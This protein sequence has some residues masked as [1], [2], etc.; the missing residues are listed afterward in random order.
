M[1]NGQ[2]MITD[3]VRCAI[4]RSTITMRVVLCCP[5][6]GI[7]SGFS[8]LWLNYT[9]EPLIS[10]KSIIIFLLDILCREEGLYKRL[11]RKKQTS[12]LYFM[13]QLLLLIS[14]L[15]YIMFRDN[16]K[17]YAFP[18]YCEPGDVISIN[19]SLHPS[20]HYTYRL[21]VRVGESQS[22]LAS[23]LRRIPLWGGH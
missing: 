12:G 11:K 7:E 2:A 19:P 22:Q 13:N 16:E 14:I 18:M 3:R 21:S 10:L 20:I 9:T 1:E 17:V 6:C 5:A 4:K 8:E 15:V 23:C